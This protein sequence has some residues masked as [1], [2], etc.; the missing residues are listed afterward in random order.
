VTLESDAPEL[1][2]RCREDAADV[3]VLVPS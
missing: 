1:L 3:V 2:R